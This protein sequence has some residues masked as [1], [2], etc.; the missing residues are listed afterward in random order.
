MM[1]FHLLSI[2]IVLMLGVVS[3]AIHS[4]FVIAGND[5]SSSHK[6]YIPTQWSQLTLDQLQQH[7]LY[8]QKQPR[9][10]I[11]FALKLRNRQWLEQLFWSVSDP[12]S[13]TY[14]QYK[15]LEQLKEII[16]PDLESQLLIHQFLR[17]TNLPSGVSIRTTPLNDF[18]VVENAPV[19]WVEA[20]FQT[21]VMALVHK[22]TKHVLFRSVQPFYVP[23][24]VK[25]VCSF[26]GGISAFRGLPKFKRA[27]IPTASNQD[28]DVT[29]IRK[30]YNI[31]DDISQG[32]APNNIQAIASFLEQYYS[33]KDLA[34]FQQRYHLPNLKVEKVIG[35][36]KEDKPGLEAS[37]DIQYIM[38]V[39]SNIRTWALSTPG[40]REGQ[41]PFLE[42]AIQIGNFTGESPYVHSVSYGDDEDSIE[43]DY[44]Q[45]LD[46]QFKILGATGRTILFASGDD[47]VG[48]KSCKSQTPDWPVSS[49]YVTAVGATT[50]SPKSPNGE[51]S[52]SWSGGGFS[53]YYPQP[54]YQQSVISAY[55]KQSKLPPRTLFNSSGRGL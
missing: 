31:S 37:L 47:G 18:I 21:K 39:G 1:R 35:P 2:F 50:P 51:K 4:E 34:Q 23:A 17:Q 30:Q 24:A 36:N 48:C 8:S 6:K 16:S 22:E 54:G 3:H 27:T 25:S 15:T 13:K 41:E 14:G 52:T 49:P 44:A 38:A 33:S 45:R 28:V 12:F 40:E 43:L 46:D 11:T 19:S 20:S 29:L 32:K 9:M 7:P 10:T 26:I 53:N 55:L 42:W 5:P